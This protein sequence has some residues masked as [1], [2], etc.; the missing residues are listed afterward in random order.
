MA[1]NMPSP[2]SGIET[3][4]PSINPA[5]RR[6]PRGFIVT[7]SRWLAV[8]RRDRRY[9]AGRLGSISVILRDHAKRRQEARREEG[10]RGRRLIPLWIFLLAVDAVK[11][12]SGFPRQPDEDG[13]FQR[14]SVR[15]ATTRSSCGTGAP[16][17]VARG[18]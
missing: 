3:A 4:S 14:A 15:G 10:G 2:G 7:W 17:R 1:F 16:V 5:A 13:V 18:H 12:A 6:R 9:R 11:C 8:S